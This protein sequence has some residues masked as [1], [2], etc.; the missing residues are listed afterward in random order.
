MKRRVKP[1]TSPVEAQLLMAILVS[2]YV[3]QV[4]P[5]SLQTFLNSRL[6]VTGNQALAK[7]IAL[8][9]T[10]TCCCPKVRGWEACGFSWILALIPENS[11]FKD[12]H[13]L[14]LSSTWRQSVF[15]AARTGL[16]GCSAIRPWY[17]FR[18][19]ILAQD[20]ESIAAHKVQQ[21]CRAM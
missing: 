16:C 4:R 14:L 17:T 19:Q 10:M 21:L 8:T 18:Y 11:M 20:A 7:D 3:L 2:L 6:E 13:C 12:P 9:Q 15:S 5:V 1:T